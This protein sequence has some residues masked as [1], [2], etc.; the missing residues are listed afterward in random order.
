LGRVAFQD[1]IDKLVVLLR[2]L[3]G[4]TGIVLRSISMLDLKLSATAQLLWAVFELKGNSR[5]EGHRSQPS[6]SL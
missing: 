3:E 2:E 4:D 5:L 6:D 1:L